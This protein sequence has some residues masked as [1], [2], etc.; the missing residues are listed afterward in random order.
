MFRRRRYPAWYAS[1]D[2]PANVASCV[3]QDIDWLE[4]CREHKLILEN[5]EIYRVLSELKKDHTPVKPFTIKFARQN[6]K[7][8]LTRKI[9][10][11]RID[12]CGSAMAVPKHMM[13]TWQGVPNV[14]FEHK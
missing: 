13:P 9:L 2:T 5:P 4:R 12:D 1:H 7:S 10:A 11:H 8:Y 14:L 3:I 6:G